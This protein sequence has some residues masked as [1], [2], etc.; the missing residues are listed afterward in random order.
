M[1]ATRRTLA[2]RLPEAVA[3]AAYEFIT[4]HC[5]P[6]RIGWAST[7][8]LRLTTDLVLGAA[9]TESSIALTTA[10]TLC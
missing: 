5:C 7:C 2:D 10:P 3:A 9:R 4:G 6:N 8:R 1:P